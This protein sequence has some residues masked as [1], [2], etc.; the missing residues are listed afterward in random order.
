MQALTEEAEWPLRWQLFNKLPADA[1]LPVRTSLREARPLG[2]YGAWKG[3]S[4][5]SKKPL[6]DTP[7]H[8]WKLVHPRAAAEDAM[9]C[10]LSQGLG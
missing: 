10:N 5:F 8:R 7:E 2:V 9:K 6:R 4:L 1:Q 3:N